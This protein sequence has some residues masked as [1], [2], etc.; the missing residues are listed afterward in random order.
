[1][2]E[3][4]PLEAKCRDKFLVQTVAVSADQE[5][6]NAQAVV[7]IALPSRELYAYIDE[8]VKHRIDAKIIDSGEK[9]SRQFPAC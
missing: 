7:R 8:V 2:K 4:P 1:M 5:V 3:D 9:D 6:A